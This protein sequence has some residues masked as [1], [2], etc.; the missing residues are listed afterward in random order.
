MDRMPYPGLE[1]FNKIRYQRD[2][3]LDPNPPELP[4]LDEEDK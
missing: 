3:A 4:K 1:R 2:Y